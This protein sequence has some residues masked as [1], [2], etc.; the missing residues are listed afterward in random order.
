MTLAWPV[1]QLQ[2]LDPD[3]AHVDLGALGVDAGDRDRARLAGQAAG[4]VERVGM[5]DR[6][7]REVD[8]AAAGELLDP[9]AGIVLGQVDRHG[10]EA[11]RPS[12]A[13]SST[14]STATTSDAPDALATWTAHRPTGPRPSTATAA[15]GLERLRTGRVA[16]DRVVGG[17]GHVAGEQR[18]LVREPVGDPAQGQVGVRHG[19]QLGLRSRQ[20][21]E[22][23]AVAEDPPGV[24]LVVLAA[25]ADR[26]SCRRRC[27]RC[28][29]PGRRP[30]TS[31]TP[32]P[33]ATTVPT[34][35]WPITKP[36][37][38]ATRP[39]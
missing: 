23:G 20:G 31:L 37:S 8:A 17:P 39:W 15:P 35:S 30:P 38:I 24:A 14:V 13:G 4:E 16:A 10:A 3:D 19:D 2:R 34:Y 27:S 9:A 1:R 22:R 26:S 21:A 28:P 29:A 7:D 6:V 12:A 32:S 36:G 33:A 11:T 18:D 25:P 5:A